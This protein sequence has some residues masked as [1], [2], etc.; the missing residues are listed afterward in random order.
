V[1]GRSARVGAALGLCLG[2]AL[3]VVSGARA[4]ATPLV[5]V[6]EG[7]LFPFY[8]RGS[9][10]A[11]VVVP[12]FQIEATPVTNAQ[13][14][15]FVQATPRWKRDQVTRLF[16]DERY[17]AHWQGPETLGAEA[18]PN[19]PVT[20][21]S[22]FAARAYC[23]SLGRQLPSEHQWELVAQA[24]ATRRDAS[25]DPAFVAQIL[26]WYSHPRGVLADVG[27][28]P[29]NRYGAHDMHGLVWEWVLDFNAV[30]VDADNRQGPD[31]ASSQFCGGGSV[32][33]RDSADYAAFMRY[34]FRSSLSAAYTVP[35]LGF[36]CAQ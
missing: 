20:H 26:S 6:D 3:L 9:A 18:R 27:Q 23:S 21:V 35:N 8:G 36:R 31:G 30:M 5:R 19:Q 1:S 34:A 29:A 12:A 4:Q 11:A 25:R 7:V 24:D 10:N 28:R 22:W 17:L 14:L 13:F 2:L 15:A 33:A 32:A 16:A